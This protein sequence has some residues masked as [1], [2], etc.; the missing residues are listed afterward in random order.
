[1]LSVLSAKVVKILLRFGF[2]PKF[3]QFIQESR[4]VKSKK[5][6]FSAL[7]KMMIIVM[8]TTSVPVCSVG[9]DFA[10]KTLFYIG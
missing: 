9:L 6:L 7:T 5:K 10:P 2:T 8:F 3:S 4:A 1:M